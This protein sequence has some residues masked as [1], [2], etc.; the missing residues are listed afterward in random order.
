MYISSFQVSN[1]KSFLESP[2]VQFAPGFNVIVGENNVG[3]TALIEAMSLRALHQPHLSV[4]TMPTPVSPLRRTD[5][6]A[7][8]SFTFDREQLFSALASLEELALPLVEGNGADDEAALFANQI[9]EQTSL[10]C[11]FAESQ[12][13]AACLYGRRVEL[14]ASKIHVAYLDENAMRVTSSVKPKTHQLFTC[15]PSQTLPFRLAQLLSSRIYLFSAER[16]KVDTYNMSP[17]PNLEP[18]AANL[19]QVLNYLQSSNPRRFDRLVELVST[20]LPQVTMITV[21]PIDGA[22]ARI[23]VWST[24]PDLQ[25]ADLAVPL[26]QSGTGIGQVLAI[27]YVVLTS[28]TPRTILIDEPQSFLHP[29]A[30]RKLI[31][32]LR[33]Y[34]QHQY[35]LTTHSPT[36]VTASNPAT[37]HLVRKEEYQSTVE[38]ISVRETQQLRRF[39]NEIGA[40]LSDVFGAD[41]V[42]WVEGSTEEECFPLIL[43]EVAKQP[44][45]GTAIV[46]VTATGDLEGKRSKSAFELYE[47]L[48]QGRGL[49]PPAVGFIFDRERRTERERQDLE[50]QS[51]QRVR[52]LDRRMYENYL[53]N[54]DAIAAVASSIDGFRD[55]PLTADEVRDWLTTYRW[56]KRYISEDAQQSEDREQW[57]RVV[58][59]ARIL[60][61]IFSHF[62]E[63]QINYDKVKYGPL[64]TKWLIEHSPDDLAEIAACLTAALQ[65]KTQ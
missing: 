43:S 34:S 7:Q 27:L 64:L 40:R 9:K 1:Y 39:L 52:F 37:L 25:R 53:L 47:K 10:I 45:L 65:H 60:E 61:D 62:S 13:S 26:A 63:G 4:T 14:S 29:G 56:N 24:D 15:S 44:L 30:I 20:I 54:A 3:K 12:L 36:V 41:N 32:I 31:D 59:G 16:L 42:L 17:Q 23:L 6:Q 33:R 51:K 2:E 48:C 19:A 55:N 58:H 18:D 8:V 28:D 35:I 21:P 46:G 22:R 11:T 57:L 49:L 5:W 38:P 50:R